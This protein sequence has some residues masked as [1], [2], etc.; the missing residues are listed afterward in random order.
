MSEKF[1]SDYNIYQNF[2]YISINVCKTFN[3][4]LI[5]VHNFSCI[6]NHFKPIYY[7]LNEYIWQIYEHRKNNF[8][9]IFKNL[10]RYKSKNNFVDPSK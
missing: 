10:I 9:K 5:I 1:N 2:R 3:K 4:P 8:V 6:Y 7:L